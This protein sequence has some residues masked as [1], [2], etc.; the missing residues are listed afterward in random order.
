MFCRMK[1]LPALGGDTIRPRWPLPMGADQVDD[2]GAQILGAAVA[3]LESQ[4]LGREQGSEV[5]E[6]DLVLGGFRPGEVDFGDLQQGEVAFAVLRRSD[7]A[8]D[9]V[10]LCA[11]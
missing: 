9:R 5:F 1:V 6:E 2:T 10:A 4:A 8:L 11:G 7:L 3:D